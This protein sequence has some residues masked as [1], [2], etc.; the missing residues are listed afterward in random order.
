MLTANGL[1]SHDALFV[2]LQ[3]HVVAVGFAQARVAVAVAAVVEQS[4]QPG[5]E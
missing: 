5:A 3:V 1:Q 4:E 2:R